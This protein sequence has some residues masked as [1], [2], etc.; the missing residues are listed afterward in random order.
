M[1]KVIICLL[2][3]GIFASYRVVTAEEVDWNSI[4]N[5]DN[6]W[7]GQKPITNK[8]FE[9]VITELEK[10]KKGNKKAN[11]PQKGQEMNKANE[12]ELLSNINTAIPLLNLPVSAIIGEKVLIPG[13]YKVI[14]EKVGDKIYLKFYQGHYMVAK[15]EAYETEDDFNS[16][17]IYFLKYETVSGNQLKIMFGSMEFNAFAFVPYLTE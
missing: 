13:H 8:E 12:T 1:R 11:K 6:A 5:P 17:E 15:T 16:E 10:R 14:G 4:G 2:I 9:Q 3:L 7:D